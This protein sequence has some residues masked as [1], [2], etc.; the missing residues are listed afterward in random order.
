MIN[1]SISNRFR[2]DFFV[3]DCF[4]CS[5]KITTSCIEF[6]LSI[7]FASYFFLRYIF[8]IEWIMF[9]WYSTLLNSYSIWHH[10]VD[11][12]CERLLIVYRE[13]F[14][15]ENKNLLLCAH[16]FFCASLTKRSL[17]VV[18]R[19]NCHHFSLSSCVLIIKSRIAR[20]ITLT[21]SSSTKTELKHLFSWISLSSFW[22]SWRWSWIVESLS[23]SFF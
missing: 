13:K 11:D 7:E 10:L 12:S 8:W 18:E 23:Y 15:Y 20:Q 3:R 1:R 21:V 2:Y 9:F 14:S 6:L 4:L 22:S 19:R 16:L 5:N 17:D